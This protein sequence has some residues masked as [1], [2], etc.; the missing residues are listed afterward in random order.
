MRR[1][2]IAAI[3][4]LLALTASAAA[5]DSF[6]VRVVAET[7]TTVTYGWDTVAGA[8]GFD[9]YVL[10]RRVSHTRDGSRTTVKFAKVDGCTVECFGIEPW[11]K[12][13]IGRANVPA[14]PTPPPPPACDLNASPSSFAAQVNAAAAGQTVCLASGNYGTWSGTNKA[15]VVKA[16]DGAAPQM[17]INLGSGD[18]SFVL[19]G[20]VGMGGDIGNGAVDV[21]I[22]NSAF[23]DVLD[24][25]GGSTDGIVLDG[26]THNWNVASSGGANAKIYLENSLTGTLAAPSVTIRNSQIKNGDLDGIH[27][28]GG[29]GYLIL[30]NVFDNLCDRGVNHTDNMQFDTSVTREVRIAGNYV[31]APAGCGTQGITSYDHGTNGVLIENNVVDIRRPW[32]IELYA[33]VGSTVRHNTLVYYPSSQCDF[34]TPCGRIDVNGKSGDPASTGTQL[35]DNL[36]VV[37]LNRC[38]GCS[39]HHNVTSSGA[40]YVGPTTTHNGFLLA[41]SSPVGRGAASDGSDAGVYANQ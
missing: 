28:G 25:A 3:A 5:A 38:T 2:V 33:D 19:D 40:V 17:K 27:F 36:A 16:A 23:T 1:I 41:P 18:G 24:I 9:F 11:S 37:E 30:N 6:A 29:S 26:N 35:F 13:V 20:M 15:I 12:T 21:T 22:R 4:A 34:N 7:A 32:A 31:H 14:K 8:D 39:Q 10:D